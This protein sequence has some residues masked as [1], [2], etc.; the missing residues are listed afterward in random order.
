MNAL[1]FGYLWAAK[2]VTPTRM[3]E[4]RTVEY[5]AQDGTVS[6]KSRFTVVEFTNPDG[7]E[8]T[9]R[10]GD[11][12]HFEAYWNRRYDDLV[13]TRIISVEP[14]AVEA[15]EQEVPAEL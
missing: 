8:F 4:E 1:E 6:R 14:A 12:V 3:S 9:V 15:A 7:T 5:T 10:E 13:F 2:G 11:V